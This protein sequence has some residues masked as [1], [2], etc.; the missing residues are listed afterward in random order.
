MIR[1]AR[2][3][4]RTVL[5]VSL[6]LCAVVDGWVRKRFFGMRVGPQGAVWVHGWCRRIARVMGL[7]LT[8]EGETP[9]A[10]EWGLAVVSNH[11]SYL[12][13]LMYSAITPFV[14]V[15]KTEVRG[16]PL[17]GWITAQAGTVYVERADVS[18]GQRQTHAEVNAMMAEAYGSGLPVLFFP[19]G[20]TTDGAGVLPF[21]RGLYHSV[22]NGGVP[23]RTA[24]IGYGFDSPNPGASVANDICYWGDMVFGPHLFG[25]L[26]LRGV[27]VRVRFGE[28]V[29]G[30]DRFVLAVR[31]REAV[32]RMYDGLTESLAGEQA[33]LVERREGLFDG[34]VERV[35]AFDRE[36]SARG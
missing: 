26:G 22:L 20:T 8:L 10:G 33:E 35:G 31:S 36:G 6:L 30:D 28:V 2:S 14:M 18:G 29:E 23:L 32:V 11:L 1:F 19:E 25:C 13:I 24:A 5:L 27:H 9:V 16:W 7:G 3:V 21:R 34:P 15:S 4:V 17:V 12:D